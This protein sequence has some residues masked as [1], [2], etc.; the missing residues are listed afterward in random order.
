MPK[1]NLSVFERSNILLWFHVIDVRMGG[2]SPWLLVKKGVTCSMQ[3]SQLSE[4]KDSLSGSVGLK[5]ADGESSLG[6]AF[7]GA[8]EMDEPAAKRSKIS[9][10]INYGFKVA[11]PDQLSCVSGATGSWE[12]AVNCAQPAEKEAK[13]VMAVEQA[14]AALGGDNGLG[15][16]DS[17]PLKTVVKLDDNAVLGTTEEG[18]GMKRRGHLTKLSVNVELYVTCSEWAESECFTNLTGEFEREVR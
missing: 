15:M 1:I 14:P 9:S 2:S 13:P 16:L 10:L 18:A 12:A 6:M 8:S 11:K 17:E 4:R 5:M 3:M 7:S